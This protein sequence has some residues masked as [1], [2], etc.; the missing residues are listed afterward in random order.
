MKLFILGANGNNRNTSGSVT[1]AN[2]NRRRFR[3]KIIFT[4]GPTVY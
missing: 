3:A 4:V 1:T 2:T